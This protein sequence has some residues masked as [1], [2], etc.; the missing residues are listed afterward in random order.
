LIACAAGAGWFHSIDIIL[1]ED[2]RSSVVK[3]DWYAGVGTSSGA[4]QVRIAAGLALGA[5]G[6]KIDVTDRLR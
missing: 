4:R 6:M 1:I 3:L 2:L 5:V